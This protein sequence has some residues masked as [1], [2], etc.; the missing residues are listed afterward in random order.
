MWGLFSEDLAFN[1]IHPLLLAPSTNLPL[2]ARDAALLDQLLD[3]AV[4]PEEGIPLLPDKV[5]LT[6]RRD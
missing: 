1:T 2:P 3:R 5:A 6:C 4:S